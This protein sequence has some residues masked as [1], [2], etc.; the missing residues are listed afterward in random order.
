MNDPAE[1]IGLQCELIVK[2]QPCWERA[3]ESV[4]YVCV[5][6]CVRACLHRVNCGSAMRNSWEFIYGAGA[7]TWWQATW[8][9]NLFYG[10]K[11]RCVCVCVCGRGGR[12]KESQVSCRSARLPT[13]HV[14]TP[15]LRIA[16][17]CKRFLH[18]GCWRKDGVTHLPSESVTGRDL[19][20]SSATCCWGGSHLPCLCVAAFMLQLCVCATADTQGSNHQSDSPQLGFQKAAK[21]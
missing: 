6:V 4:N 2:G 9:H 12:A 19:W 10:D 1:R 13:Q 21:G 8:Q 7:Q 3:R 14:H 16:K 15:P 18:I 17:S 20:V 11:C 5:C